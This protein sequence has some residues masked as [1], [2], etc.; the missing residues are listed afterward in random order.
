MCD[1]KMGGEHNGGCCGGHMS[2]GR[3]SWVCWVLGFVVL[4]IVF[5]TGYKLGVLRGYFGGWG[6]GGGY[7]HPMM[8]YRGGPVNG[9]SA[10][11]M[12]NWQYRTE[13]LE[14]QV[15]STLPR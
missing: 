1:N 12:G 15:T 7:G 4:V 9:Y 6:F 13:V 11:M 3:K 8:L 2:W 14:D 10:G 5:C